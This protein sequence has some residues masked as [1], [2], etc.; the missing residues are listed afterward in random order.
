MQTSEL[1]EQLGRLLCTG[2]E[3]DVFHDYL[4]LY[5]CTVSCK[6]QNCA[7]SGGSK[8]MLISLTPCLPANP[9]RITTS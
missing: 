1:V 9:V 8:H 6:I 4:L 3:S 2:G 5:K 7:A